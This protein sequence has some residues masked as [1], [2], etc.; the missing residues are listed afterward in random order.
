MAKRNPHA[1]GVRS[2]G[3]GLTIFS[4][5]DVRAI[6][7]STLEVLERTGVWIESDEA[8][9]IFS[10]G[11][12]VVDHERHVVKIPPHIVEE[13]IAA[14][15]SRVTLCGRDA[16]HDI[17][18]EPGRV[19]FTNFSEG[20]MVVDLHTGEHRE[21]R[22]QDI[23]DIAR[24]ND[25]LSEIDTYGGAVGAQD[26]PPQT[27]AIH[28]AEAQFLNTTKPVDAGPLGREDARAIID[29][30]ATIVGGGDELRERPILFLGVCPVSPLTAAPRSPCCPSSHCAFKTLTSMRSSATAS[31]AAASTTTTSSAPS[32]IGSST[33]NSFRTIFQYSTVLA[34]PQFTSLQTTKNFNADFLFTYLINP[35]TAL[36]VG[37][38]GNLQNLDLF[39]TTMGEQILGT[40]YFTHDA[41][42]FF[43][44]FSYFAFLNTPE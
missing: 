27:A 15:P 31:K 23:A 17:V 6:H 16:K 40:P 21:S 18:L 8:L 34:N 25:Y 38:N 14:A 44:K 11:G 42:Q 19:G 22:K 2:S 35:W 10:D 26:V 12:C 29:M 43:I 32:G 24:L 20:I 13:A 33:G 4:D 36:Y 3:L 37:Y 1:G 28:N 39:P 9:H 30:A 41:R 5:D 7:L